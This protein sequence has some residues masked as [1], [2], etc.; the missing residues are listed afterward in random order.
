M[1]AEQMD[2]NITAAEKSNLVTTLRVLGCISIAGCVA[3]LIAYLIGRRHVSSLLLFSY[4]IFSS[5]ICLTHQDRQTT[6]GVHM[7]AILQGLEL[8][9]AIFMTAGPSEIADGKQ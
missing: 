4:Q 1:P 8:V 2:E 5:I 9:R 7:V 3:V 6:I